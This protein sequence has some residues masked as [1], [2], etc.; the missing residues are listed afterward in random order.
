[1][2]PDP[3]LRHT[4]WTITIGTTF[5]WL[6]FLGIHPGSIQR[7]VALPTVN[8]ARKALIYFIVGTCVIKICSTTIGMLIYTK[9]KDCD[10]IMAGVSIFSSLNSNG[11]VFK[12]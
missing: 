3:F 4:F 8:K 1:M 5:S 11:T 10:P 7:F 2:D 9:F 12:A 6:N